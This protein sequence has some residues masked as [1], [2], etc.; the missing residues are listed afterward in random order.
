MEEYEFEAGELVMLRSGGPLMVISELN[1]GPN[2]FARCLFFS[3]DRLVTVE[4]PPVALEY[5]EAAAEEEEPS[6]Q[7]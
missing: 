7:E 4:I 3:E 5:A 2:R 6:V 1:I